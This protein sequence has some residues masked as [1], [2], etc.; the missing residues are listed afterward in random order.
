MTEASIFFAKGPCFGSTLGLILSYRDI[1]WYHEARTSKNLY[2]NSSFQKFACRT[3]LWLRVSV[4]AI[5]L[6]YD[7]MR[8][9]KTWHVDASLLKLAGPIVD[10]GIW[11]LIAA[12]L[13]W[14]RS[15]NWLRK[16]LEST[17]CLGFFGETCKTVCKKRTP[18]Y[19]WVSYWRAPWTWPFLLARQ[20]AITQKCKRADTRFKEHSLE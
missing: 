11:W 2:F 16:S 9:H 20:Y 18:N 8:L 3:I 1:S 14:V 19:S 6:W 13:Q 15:K 10:A 7:L 4:L 17:G 5:G 12:T